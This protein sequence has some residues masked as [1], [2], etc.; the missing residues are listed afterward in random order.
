MGHRAGS[1]LSTDNKASLLSAD[2]NEDRLHP[3]A[4]LNTDEPDTRTPA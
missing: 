4:V 2:N 3:P 1:L